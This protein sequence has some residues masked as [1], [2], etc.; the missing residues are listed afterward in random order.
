MTIRPLQPKSRSLLKA[1]G[2][3][4]ISTEHQD[5][6]SLEDQ[7]ALLRKFVNENYSG[8]VEWKF[9]IS[10]GSGEYL[11]RAEFIEL[12]DDIESGEFDLVV[13][14]DLS[15]VCRRV[16][17]ILLCE[18]GQDAGTRIIA[19]NDRVDTAEY[20]WQDLAIF[21]AIHHER[22]NRDTS[23]RIRRSLRNRHSNGGV[24]Q[25]V[26]YGFIKLDGAKCDADIQKDPEA[27]RIYD[28][29]FTMLEQGASFAEVADWLNDNSVPV[30]RW[31]KK[32]KWDGSLVG[33]VTRNEILKGD[34]IR[35]RRKSVRINKTGR[36]K[37]VNAPAEERLIRH[38]PHLVIIDPARWDRVIKLLEQ[39]NKLY[40]RK[41]DQNGRDPRKNVLKKQTRF[42]GQLIECGIC[43]RGFVFGGHGQTDHLMCQGAREHQC[44]NGATVDG[45]LARKK[46]L[47]AVLQEVE[48]IPEF[49][50]TFLELVQHEARQAD[51][52]AIRQQRELE[53]KIAKC[54][55]QLDNLMVAI[56]K[57]IS[58]DRVQQELDSL[59]SERR[60]LHQL[61]DELERRPRESVELPAVEELKARARHLMSRID[62]ESWEF[63]QAIS[64]LIPK[65]VVF[66][67]RLIDGNAIVLRAKFRLYLGNFGADTNASEIL[68]EPLQRVLTVDLFEPPQREAFRKQI[69]EWRSGGDNGQRL[70]EKEIAKKLGLTVTAVQRAASLQRQMDKL[71]V[72]DAYQPVH[73]PPPKG[74]LK[75]HLHPRYNFQPLP[76]AGEI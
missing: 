58:S 65:I 7:E 51:E 74:K 10:Q 32:T 33:Q 12:G 68:K 1:I 49:D 54:D 52:A 47:D 50:E 43:G 26:P 73:E 66:P 72:D 71:G 23:D 22:S 20:G 9:I 29:W 28:Q 55:R 41:G 53:Q 16:H 70:T 19:L 45:P 37:S 62:M 6:K 25:T 8:P 75:R 76:G 61:L 34:R 63:R 31:V 3:C 39:R 24:V 4:R 46:I 21:S 30:G 56:R 2:V 5:E 36:R 14:E 13:A 35:N 48:Q 64:A 40:R 17:A 59:E 11:D 15:R 44:W 57:G 27:E 67:Y 18:S 69:M 42:P 60:E 38:C